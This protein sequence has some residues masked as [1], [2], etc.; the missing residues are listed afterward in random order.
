MVYIIEALLVIR[1]LNAQA[2]RCQNGMLYG[3]IVVTET[4]DTS[5][6]G[7]VCI[8]ID[9]YIDTSQDGRL[10]IESKFVLVSCCIVHFCARNG[11]KYATV[12]ITTNMILTCYR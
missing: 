11:C 2:R 3:C 12:C 1:P 10:E 4:F 6:G 8:Y 9:T 5:S 7:S